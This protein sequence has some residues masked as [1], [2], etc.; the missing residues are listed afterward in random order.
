MAGSRRIAQLQDSSR[1]INLLRAISGA[2]G[3]TQFAQMASL[4][5]SFLVAG[6]SVLARLVPAAAP[7]L[8]LTGA[9]WAATYALLVIPWRNQYLRTSA[10]LQEMFDVALFDLAWN[11]VMVGDRVPEDEVS[12]LSRRYRRDEAR[13]RGYYLV[14]DVPAPYD[15]LFCLEQNLAWGSRVRRR[16]ANVLVAVVVLWC[17]TGVAVALATGETVSRLLSEWFVPALGLLLLCLDTF[18]AHVSVTQER[19]RVLGL[20]RAV[21]DDPASPVLA[22]PDSFA[23][24]ARQV[25]DVLFQTRRQQPRVPTWFFQRFHDSDAADFRYKMQA[26]EAKL[27]GAGPVAPS[28]PAAP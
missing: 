26:L 7:A 25:Q 19:T 11:Q 14:A 15:V 3:H 27:A 18:R 21:A 12:R 23:T 28:H 10:T 1:S 17:G 6:L 4:V 22:S 16:F 24:F 8:A 9:V 5:V 13:L 20:V 2:H